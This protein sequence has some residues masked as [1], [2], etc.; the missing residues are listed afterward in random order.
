MMVLYAHDITLILLV[1][2]MNKLYSIC[3]L[4]IQWVLLYTH[5]INN[6]YTIDIQETNGDSM[7]KLYS[8]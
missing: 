3:I 2:F 5:C 8:V 1:S 4:L 7:I 6:T